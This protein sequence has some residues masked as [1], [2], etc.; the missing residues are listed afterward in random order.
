M[1]LTTFGKG[2]YQ[3]PSCHDEIIAGTRYTYHWPQTVQ[4][5]AHEEH[6]NDNQDCKDSSRFTKIFTLNDRNINKSSQLLPTPASHIRSKNSDSVALISFCVLYFLR[7]FDCL[8]VNL[9]ICLISYLITS[10]LFVCLFQFCSC[11]GLCLSLTTS[12]FLQTRNP[13]TLVTERL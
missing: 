8:L 1:L 9:Q 2:R 12:C 10:L 3:Q 11:T 4:L 7:L 6:P 13:V 5:W